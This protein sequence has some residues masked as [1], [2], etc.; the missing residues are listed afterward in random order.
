MAS[1]VPDNE[2]RDFPEVPDVFD[3]ARVRELVELMRAHELSEIDLREGKRR[4]RLRRGPESVPA[5]TG[6][7]V[8]FPIF[9][10]GSAPVPPPTPA[11]PV[12]PP[13]VREPEA[14]SEAPKQKEEENI[15]FIRSPMVGTFY[16]A[17]DP[18]SP[19]YVKVGDMVGPDTVVGIVEAMKVFNEIP[20]EVSGQIVAI[21]VENGEPV[22]SG[23]PLFK[24]DT[25]A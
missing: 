7:A 19:P 5:A 22:E 10:P 11:G 18:D 17:P 9:M 2:G 4:I 25:K 12:T 8:P 21:L 16:A 14:T 15:V 23:Q 20:A 1:D 24:V 13:P 6:P 3:L